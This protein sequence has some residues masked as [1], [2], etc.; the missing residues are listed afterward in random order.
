MLLIL[1][2]LS[3]NRTDNDSGSYEIRKVRDLQVLEILKVSVPSVTLQ[4]RPMGCGNQGARR[5]PS[6][7]VPFTLFRSITQVA[8]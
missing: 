3:A 1:A 2:L 6:T 5:L 8:P 4:D 7:N